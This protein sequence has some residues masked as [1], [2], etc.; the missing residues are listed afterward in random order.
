MIK[1][2]KSPKGLLKIVEMSK[3]LTGVRGVA[4]VL[5][6]GRFK[7]LPMIDVKRMELAGRKFKLICIYE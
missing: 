3:R 2:V 4:L 1:G 7:Y 6:D 5:V